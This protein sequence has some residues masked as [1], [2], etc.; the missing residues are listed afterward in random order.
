M[1]DKGRGMCIC[2]GCK[3]YFCT[4]HFNEHRQ[5]LSMQ[6]DRDV[7]KIHDDLLEQIHSVKQPNIVSDD[8]CAQIDDWETST[9][10]KIKKAAQLAR[11]Q[12]IQLFSQETQSLTENLGTVADEIRTVLKEDSF[13][14]D[15]IER[16][17]LN[18]N[19][20]R[21]SLDQQSQTENVKLIIDNRIDWNRL[22]YA[23]KQKGKE[24]KS[25][26]IE[27]CFPLSSILFNEK[28]HFY[29]R[30]SIAL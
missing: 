10:V 18:L 1:C 2:D 14:E 17:Q 12:V 16:L 24:K 11:H 21:K 3:A 22:I 27:I 23:E 19:Q 6:F 28:G 15:D 4:R 26:A 7:V 8:L 20:L 30:M 25:S 13:A 29:F 9:I 5:Q